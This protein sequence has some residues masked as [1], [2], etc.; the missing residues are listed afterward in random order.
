MVEENF[1]LAFLEKRLIEKAIDKYYKDGNIKIYS[2]LGI[3]E[4]TFYR[5]LKQHK[6][7]RYPHSKQNNKNTC[8]G[9]LQSKEGAENI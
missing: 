4:S 1:N 7:N 5:R 2:V 6:I 3:S 9:N 8:D